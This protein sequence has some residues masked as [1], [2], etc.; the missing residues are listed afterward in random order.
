MPAH[1]ADRK[2]L[3]RAASQ[4]IVGAWRNCRTF[5]KSSNPQDPMFSLKRL[6]DRMKA[7]AGADCRLRRKYHGGR[8]VSTAGYPAKSNDCFGAMAA[9]T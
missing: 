3:C 5:D 6:C 2:R 8:A 9:W 4:H 1:T 7:P